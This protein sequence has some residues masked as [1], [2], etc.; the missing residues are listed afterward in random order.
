MVENI[1]LK[2]YWEKLRFHDWTY[3]M[4]DDGEVYR[5]G[6]AAHAKIKSY[7]KLSPE[8]QALFDAFHKHVWYGDHMRTEKAPMPECPA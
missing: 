1:T 3:M 6:D 8:H 7:G 2:E 4:S 5:R